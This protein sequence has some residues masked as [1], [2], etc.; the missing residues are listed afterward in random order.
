MLYGIAIHGSM[1]RWRLVRSSVLQCLSWDQHCF[2]LLSED[3][4]SGIKCTLSNFAN[5]TKLS[6]AVDTTKGRDDICLDL[7]KLEK[8]AHVNLNRF[9]KSKCKALHLGQGNPRHEDRLGEELLE[10]SPAEKDLWVLLDKMFDMS[11]QCILA[12][13]KPTAPQAPSTEECP[14]G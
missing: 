2:I 5:D 13:Q 3:V 11:Q 10:S 14:A 4:D 1:S 9:N 8:W 6:G 12:A 7:S